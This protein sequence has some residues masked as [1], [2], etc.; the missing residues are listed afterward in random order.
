MLS[1][2]RVFFCCILVI[3]A[4]VAFAEN[5]SALSIG[6][7]LTLVRNFDTTGSVT[8]DPAIISYTKSAGASECYEVDAAL[9]YDYSKVLAY[10]VD[11]ELLKPAFDTN[12]IKQKES[13]QLVRLNATKSFSDAF[14]FTA[15]YESEKITGVSSFAG[16]FDYTLCDSKSRDTSSVKFNP[17]YNLS[18]G[19]N[20]STR[21][22]N[23]VFLVLSPTVKWE[24]RQYAIPSGTADKDNY[25]TLGVTAKVFDI[26][27]GKGRY[28]LKPTLSIPIAN[29]DHYSLDFAYSNGSDA[30]EFVVRQ[31]FTVGLGCKF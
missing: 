19:L 18:I 12:A 14:T 22:T 6:D 17:S 1:V 9:R 13:R 8:A 21:D 15:M 20:A 27:S 30:P 7:R 2:Q 11:L 10:G 29:N 16:E 24:Y 25:I 4:L 5:P 28:L 26:F 31:T 3:L 23:A